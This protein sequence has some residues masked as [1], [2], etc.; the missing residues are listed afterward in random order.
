LIVVDASAVVAVLLADETDFGNRLTS[1]R[2][3]SNVAPALCV[4]EVCNA[5]VSAVRRGRLTADGAKAALNVFYDFGIL[6]EAPP[7]RETAHAISA[8]CDTHA[9]SGYDA[10]YI[11]LAVRKGA[12]LATNDKRLA[13]IAKKLGVTVQ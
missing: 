12:T 13:G 10:A 8:L 7:A 2:K 4:F 6:I 3:D 5:L 11:E 9:L 1:L